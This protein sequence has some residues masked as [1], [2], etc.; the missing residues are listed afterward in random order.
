MVNFKNWDLEHL[1]NMILLGFALIMIVTVVHVF[2]SPLLV[3]LLPSVFTTGLTLTDT[4][5]FLIL[6]RLIV[7]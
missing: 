4:L 5:L 3:T 6:M 2:V 7:K 1:G